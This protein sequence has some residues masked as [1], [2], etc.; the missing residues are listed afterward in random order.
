[1]DEQQAIDE[2]SNVPFGEM[3]CC[4]NCHHWRPVN[5][6]RKDVSTK[7]GGCLAS[8]LEETFGLPFVRNEVKGPPYNP[9]DDFCRNPAYPL[10]YAGNICDKH[11]RIP[12]VDL[13]IALEQFL[14]GDF[15]EPVTLDGGD[16]LYMLEALNSIWPL[17]V[18]LVESERF[19]HQHE[20]EIVQAMVHWVDTYFDRTDGEAIEERPELATY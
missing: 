18:R 11:E 4:R 1:M 13:N 2:A 5:G 9:A 3:D 14:G 16:F 19:M 20:A 8:C 17:I 12:S 10:T 6:K 7:Q 15:T